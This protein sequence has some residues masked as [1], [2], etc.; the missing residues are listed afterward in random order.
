VFAQLIV[1]LVVE[2]FDGCFLD[3]PVHP[4]DLAVG[5]RMLGFGCPVVDIVP[6]AGIFEGMC[7]DRSP[8]AMASLIIG[9]AD[10]PAPGVVNWMPLSVSTVWI[11]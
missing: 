5:P 4:F 2:A 8:L 6:C 9:T 11:L 1:G 10:R 3:C 7:P